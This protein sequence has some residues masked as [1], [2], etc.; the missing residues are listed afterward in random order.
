MGWKI[1]G[2]KEGT[3]TDWGSE[4]MQKLRGEEER[5][6][7]SIGNKLAQFFHISLQTSQWLQETLSP[8]QRTSLNSHG[9]GFWR[10]RV[11]TSEVKTLRQFRSLKATERKRDAHRRE[12]SGRVFR[13]VARNQALNNSHFDIQ[14]RGEERG[15][16]VGGS[17]CALLCRCP[18]THS[19]ISTH[20]H[21]KMRLNGWESHTM[22]CL[23]HRE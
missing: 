17:H 11:N 9:E 14:T 18:P 10:R 13:P 5:N 20:T 2:V 1:Q 6:K 4:W 19:R 7:S 3:H 8:H 12:T 22:G 16:R 15:S 21:F 23:Q